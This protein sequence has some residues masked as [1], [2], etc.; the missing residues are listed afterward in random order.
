MSCATD[1]QEP[2]QKPDTQDKVITTD[3]Q[4]ASSNSTT[5]E[6]QKATDSNKDKNENTTTD[7]INDK[8]T[9]FGGGNPCTIIYEDEY[10]SQALEL[11]QQLR[12]LDKKSSYT[13]FKSTAS[14]NDDDSFEILLGLT[15]RD[16]SIQAKNCLNTYLDFSIITTKNKIAIYAN[17]AERLNDAIEYFVSSLTY[18]SSNMLCYPTSESYLNVYKSYAYPNLSISSVSIK[19][20]S[21]I[22]PKNATATENNAAVTLFNWIATNTG[23]SLTVKTDDMPATNNE[24]IIGNASRTECADYGESIAESRIYSA[25]TKGGKLLLYAGNAGSYAS[26]IKAFT[27]TVALTKGEVTAINVIKNAE[28]TTPSTPSNPSNPTPTPTP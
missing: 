10:S 6:T 9:A 23:Y 24:I 3:K 17:T 2:L 15:D 27:D 28:S 7:K 18:T 11:T 8:L 25:I 12:T 1:S 26:S 5:T 16:L 22:I 4:N 21:I 13:A 20:F 19:S 14:K